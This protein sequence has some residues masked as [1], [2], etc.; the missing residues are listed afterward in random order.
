MDRKGR[1]RGI[2]S[3]GN[4]SYKAFK[5]HQDEDN[6]QVDEYSAVEFGRSDFSADDEDK[7]FFLNFIQSAESS[8][9]EH[10]AVQSN[11]Q[12]RVQS[13][14]ALNEICGLHNMPFVAFCVIHQELV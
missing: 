8:Q 12:P 4:N 3:E 10:S 2:H 13:S 9:E 14:R 1:S 6:K 11:Y 5:S 7:Y